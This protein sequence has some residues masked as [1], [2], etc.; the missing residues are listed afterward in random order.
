[1]IRIKERIKDCQL[2]VRARL[3]S[4]SELLENELNTFS[5]KRVRGFLKP[6]LIKRNLIEYTGP[7]GISLLERLGKPITKRDFFFLIEQ[8]A[9]ATQRLQTQSFLW[10]RVVWDVRYTYINETTKEVQLLY[11]PLKGTAVQANISEFLETIIYSAKPADARDND[12]IAEFVYFLKSLPHYDP[13][14]IEA[15]IAQR[16]RSVI[17]V[18]KRSAEGVSEFMTDKPKDY[19]EHYERKRSKVE[20]ANPANGTAASRPFKQ[21]GRL[22]ELLADDVAEATGLLVD[23]AREATVLLSDDM[24]EATGLL[25]DDAGGATGLLYANGS[26]GAQY[27]DDDDATGLLTPESHHYPSLYRVLTKEVIRVNKAVFRL[28][29]ERSYV[30]YFV[31]NNNAVSR[32]HADIITRGKRCF[33]LDLNSKNKTYINGR[34]IPAQSEC[35]IYDGDHLTLGNEEFVFNA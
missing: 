34:A 3:S 8:I 25:S 10:N 30:D 13:E 18:I 5:R 14:K 11:L 27:A 28:G 15:Y 16:D 35:E 6:S 24:G 31:T 21:G 17:N 12:F 7:I 23:D 32:S 20:P 4:D 9:D 2:I 33:V 1:M 29:K 26:R 19:Y 22:T